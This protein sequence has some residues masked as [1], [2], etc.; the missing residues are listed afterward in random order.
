VWVSVQDGTVNTYM[1]EQRIFIY[2]IYVKS[3]SVHVC[4][5]E[6][7]QKFPGVDIPA[8]STI[9]YLVNKYKT[10]GSVLDKKIKT[11]HYILTEEKLH[12]TGA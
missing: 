5:R 3:N 1:A 8:R 12:E 11:V 4:H 2:E 10:T 7:K 9:R 6:F